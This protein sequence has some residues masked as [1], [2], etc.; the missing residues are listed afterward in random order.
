MIIYTVR[1]NKEKPRIFFYDFFLFFQF[2][3]TRIWLNSET[4]M[5]HFPNWSFSHVL[6]LNFLFFFGGR[7]RPVLLRAHPD[8]DIIGPSWWTWRTIWSSEYWTRG[9]CVR[10]EC[11]AYCTMTLNLWNFYSEWVM[12]LLNTYIYKSIRPLLHLY[13]LLT[14]IYFIHILYSWQS[15]H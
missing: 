9:F 2:C 14:W 12:N 3:T 13:Y 10:G 15:R 8:S 4:L 1:D 11:P 5:C 7:P 6:S